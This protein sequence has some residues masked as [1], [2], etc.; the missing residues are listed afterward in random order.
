MITNLKPT[1]QGGITPQK[2]D[3]TGQQLER[4]KTSL[5]FCIQLNSLGVINLGAK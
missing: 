2:D 4:L 1:K 3:E 5:Y